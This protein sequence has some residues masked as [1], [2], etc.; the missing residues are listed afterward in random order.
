MI[1]KRCD[2][3]GN[4]DGT[5][6]LDR[7]MKKKKVMFSD[8]AFLMT[9]KNSRNEDYNTYCD[10]YV[11]KASDTKN[12]IKAHESLKN[13]GMSTDLKELMDSV[14]IKIE[15]P[16]PCVCDDCK[17]DLLKKFNFVVGH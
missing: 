8:K 5:F 4:C 13:I 14:S 3:C 6:V 12:V 16:Y 10:I 7:D 15:N 2:I 9:M 11:E 17:I 1:V